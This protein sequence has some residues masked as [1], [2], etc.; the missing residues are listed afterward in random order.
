[1]IRDSVIDWQELSGLYERAD[2][3]DENGLA[4]FLAQ[5]RLEKHRLLAQLE[6]MLDARSRIAT[7]TFLQGLPRIET[8][9]LAAPSEWAEGSRIGAY[10]LIRHLGSG[11][12]AEV[13]LAE[14]ADGAF[15]RQVAI[16]LL[17]N[18]PT[19]AQRDSFVER[20]KRE[21][22]ILAS[23]HH[24]NI[25]GL[26]DAGVTPGGQ[27]W[28]ALE[29]VEG[30]PITAWCDARGLTI[31]ARVAVF[32]QMLLAVEYAHA[33]L[34]IHRD[35]K[36]SN[37]LVTGQGE[38]KLLD[39][40][41]AKLIEGDGQGMADTE[42][43]RQ[44]GRPLTVLYASPEQVEGKSLTTASDVYSAGVVLYELVTGLRPYDVTEPSPARLAAAIISV[45]PTP[46]SRRVP[47]GLEA[48]QSPLRQLGR[49]VA[50][51]LDAVV[52]KALAKEPV[53][54][55]HSA[56]AMRIDLGRWSEHRPVEAQVPSAAYRARRFVARHK[57]GV[58]LASGAIA[59]LL[60]VTTAAVVLGVKAR[61]ESERA[62]ATR[63]FVQD[64]FR[65][66]DPDQSRGND[67]TARSILVK[68]RAN[69][70]QMFAAQPVLLGE[71]LATIGDMQ[72]TSGDH[73]E[74]DVTLRRVVEVFRGEGRSRESAHALA[75]LAMNAFFLGDLGRASQLGGEAAALAVD[76]PRDDALQGRILYA[77]AWVANASGR[78]AEAREIMLQAGLREDA[79]D[80]ES[81]RA[82]DVRQGLAEIEL[83]L[84]DRDA[85]LANM[86]DAEERAQRSAHVGPRARVKTEFARVRYEI[87]AGQYDSAAQLLERL[88]PSCEERL[89]RQ[90]EDCIIMR[91]RQVVALVRTGRR[92]AARSAAMQIVP[93]I[94]GESSPRRLAE[95]LFVICQAL[96]LVEK[97]SELAEYLGRLRQVSEAQ[98]QSP[99]FRSIALMTLSEVSLL[100]GHVDDA[101][102]LANRAIVEQK[103]GAVPAVRTARAKLLLGLAMQRQKR[104]QE[105]LAAFGESTSM[106]VQ[107][108]GPKHP[109]TLL[110]R[111]NAIPSMRAVGQVEPARRACDEASSPLA[112]ALGASSPAM[113][114]IRDL[115]EQ[116]DRSTL[117]VPF[118]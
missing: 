65:V 90:A 37:I 61:A 48:K 27:P 72:V 75:E 12:M 54:R 69:A 43:T 84:G 4:A 85:A 25:A 36:P 108:M 9:P 60:T 96:A 33:N 93:T 113:Q 30:E 50:G 77:Q 91:R 55:Y 59:A 81:E 100:G 34:V 52:M 31:E 29:V 110:F 40:G 99:A 64:I 24:P 10:R 62:V 6:R 94:A 17:F 80:R 7:G 20:F 23:L 44:M 38:V 89:G 45:E 67:I 57:L 103:A 117:D 18:H 46:P 66:A 109:L 5:L 21:R 104:H 41:I 70:E 86:R 8:L 114:R 2:V 63:N 1:M 118:L 3:L 16:K 116:H 42:L 79:V 28:L 76:Y 71:V 39:F 102:A 97:P 32:R 78:I 47:V 92:E 11:G 83:T 58:S 106:F 98:E 88:I 111:L 49:A 19:R 115:C 112:A 87:E 82:I 74:A 73:A 35:L 51:D 22:D 15:E 107:A 56:E 53:N 95:S 105:A 101:E 68:G 14:R 26:H 13:W